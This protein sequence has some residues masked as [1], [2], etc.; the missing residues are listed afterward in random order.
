MLIHGQDQPEHGALI[1]RRDQLDV[2]AMAA[3]QVTGDG[4]TET[5]TMPPHQV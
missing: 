1:R 3:Q 5:P 4:E 2:T